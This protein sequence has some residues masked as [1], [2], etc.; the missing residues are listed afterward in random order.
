VSPADR[1][2]INRLVHLT[3]AVW[4]CVWRTASLHHSVAVLTFLTKPHMMQWKAKQSIQTQLTLSFSWSVFFYQHYVNKR[5][6]FGPGRSNPEAFL[7]RWLE[8]TSCT[9]LKLSTFV[10]NQRC[11]SFLKCN[12]YVQYCTN[13]DEPWVTEFTLQNRQKIP[14]ITS[15]I[16]VLGPSILISSGDWRLCLGLKWL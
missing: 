11:V 1:N 13:R 9:S 16:P 5:L 12:R 2:R 7:F 14:F 8:K 10:P 6:A 3:F 15:Y 4:T